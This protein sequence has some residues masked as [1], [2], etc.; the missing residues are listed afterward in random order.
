[1]DSS[2]EGLQPDVSLPNASLMLEKSNE[3]EDLLLHSISLP[4]VSLDGNISPSLDCE[5]DQYSCY[6]NAKSAF[7]SG[8][9]VSVDQGVVW[10]FN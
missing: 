10:Y 2:L 3:S 8:E 1:M 4:D 9:V 5:A 6:M 7:T